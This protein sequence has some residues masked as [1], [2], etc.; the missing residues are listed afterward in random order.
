M[1]VSVIILNYN[2]WG[3]LK[4][5]LD[6]LYRFTRDV[7]FEVIVVDNGSDENKWTALQLD[8]SDVIFIRNKKNLGFSGGN[9][10]GANVAKGKYLL[11]LNVDTIFCENLMKSLLEIIKSDTKIG[12]AG[13]KLFN[14]D[15]SFQLSCGQLP[16]ILVEFW[17]K[18]R[19]FFYRKGGKLFRSFYN[20]EY[21]RI[22]KIGWVTGACMIV[23]AHVFKSVNGFDENYFMYYEDK[24]LCYRIKNA[25]WD[26]IYAP[27]TSIIHLMAGASK[28][29]SEKIIRQYYRKS[30][31]YY[32]KKHL[33]GFQQMILRLYLYLSGKI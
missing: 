10:I 13:P 30:Q 23:N 2:S 22:K 12:V 19:Y 21:Q 32:Y 29:T 25:G 8:Y 7:V 28:N 11:F 6:S 20:N 1:D 17:D 27:S 4:D 33:D 5:C 16:N 14:S 9:N 3:L 26:V 24:D 15:G 31:V 18:I